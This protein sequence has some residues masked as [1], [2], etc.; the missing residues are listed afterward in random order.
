M[1]IKQEAW[2][3]P[4]PPAI[5]PGLPGGSKHKEFHALF[6][7]GIRVRT[8]FITTKFLDCSA[9]YTHLIL[10]LSPNRD[11][12]KHKFRDMWLS[13]LRRH[14]RYHMTSEVAMT[15]FLKPEGKE[16]TGHTRV[17]LEGQAWRWHTTSTAH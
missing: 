1:N 17:A 14:C 15:L 3:H 10:T 5:N 9:Q 13:V 4:P 8:S 11:L 7:R 12:F 2:K 6:F 16:K